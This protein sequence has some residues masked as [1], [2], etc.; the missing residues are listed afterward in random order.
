MARDGKVEA[1]KHKVD[2]LAKELESFVAGITGS[3]SRSEG[4]TWMDA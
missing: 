2:L 3:G 4:W 1:E